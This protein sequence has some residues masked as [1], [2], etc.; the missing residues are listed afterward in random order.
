MRKFLQ[1]LFVV[2]VV[3]ALALPVIAQ[4]DEIV[5]DTEWV[6]PEEYAGQTLNVY[7][8]ASYIGESTITDFEALCDVDV[9]YDV[10]DTNESLIARL[11]TGNP[12]YDVAFPNDYAVA[13]MIREEL[14]QPID[15]DNI[16]NF[17]NVAESFQGLYYDPDNEY[18]VPYLWGTTGVGYNAENV[19]E[20]TSYMDVFTYD[21]PVAWL[22]DVRAMMAV[23]L[24]VL[25]YNPSSQDPDELQEAKDFLLEHSDNVVAISSDDGQA[26][27]ERGEVDISFEYNGDIY[28]LGVDCECETFE[29]AVPPELALVDITNLVLLT[30]A[31]NPALAQVFMD[32]VL[33]PAV[34]G[35]ITSETGYATANLAAIEGEFVDEELLANSS[36][37]PDLETMTNISFYE[38]VGEAEQLY[39]DIWDEILILVG[40]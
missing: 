20:L 38:E 35:L 16:P 4:D 19:G 40:E 17:E 5:V 32:Y 27:L 15:L 1:L 37:Y 18:S 9:T 2:L 14:L 12:G 7:N 34:N 13:I 3:T 23:A 21:G 26:L 24:G 11:R 6:C 39:N 36:I 28:Q 22:N 8:W 30:D 10:F 25:G 33:D 29:Y 31:P